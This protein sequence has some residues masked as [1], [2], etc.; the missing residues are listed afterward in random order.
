[1]H[2][3]FGPLERAR[4]SGVR[5]ERRH[6]VKVAAGVPAAMAEFRA[7]VARYSV[8]SERGEDAV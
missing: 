2:Q 4:R 5:A 1:M 7:P 3:P 6:L 8:G